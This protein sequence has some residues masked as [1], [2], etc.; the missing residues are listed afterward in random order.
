[1]KRQIIYNGKLEKVGS[2]SM[3]NIRNKTYDVIKKIVAVL[4]LV[5]ALYATL[6]QIW[7]WGLGSEIDGTV[8]ALVS[9]LNGLLG[10]FMLASSSAYHKG[11]AKKKKKK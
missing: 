9:F 2:V 3:L 7:G 1:M 5:T 6:A 4:P 8:T 11:D 10:V